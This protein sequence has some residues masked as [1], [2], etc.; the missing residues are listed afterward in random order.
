[1]RPTGL[2]KLAIKIGLLLIIIWRRGIS[3]SELLFGGTGRLLML[4]EQTIFIMVEYAR[5]QRGYC[6]ILNV[7]NSNGTLEV[8][9]SVCVSHD[10]VGNGVFEIAFGTATCKGRTAAR[11][12]LSNLRHDF[13]SLRVCKSF[14]VLLNLQRLGILLK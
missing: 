8:N 11:R 7:V 13:S 14:R 9:V 1:L 6:Q 10:D 4:Q 2:L 12:I 3:E 5:R